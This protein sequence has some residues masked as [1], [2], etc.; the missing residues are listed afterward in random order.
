MS[1]RK[2]SSE[3]H[4]GNL[5]LCRQQDQS[6]QE[7]DISDRERSG[8]LRG[9]KRGERVGRLKNNSG[10]SGDLG[11]SPVVYRRQ[12]RNTQSLV[13][14]SSGTFILTRQRLQ[15]CQ[16]PIMDKEKEWT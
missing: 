10:S 12:V 7:A 6:G 16:A 3:G 8:S 11:K 5:K 13:N 15:L 14:T 4:G 2:T 9:R 1:T